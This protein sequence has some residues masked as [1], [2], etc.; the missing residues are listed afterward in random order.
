MTSNINQGHL[1]G[2]PESHPNVKIGFDY[3]FLL[4]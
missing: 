3:E 1:M 4:I 2:N